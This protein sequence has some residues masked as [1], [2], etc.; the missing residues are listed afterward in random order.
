M[1]TA[2]RLTDLPRFEAEGLVEHRRELAARIGGE[3]PALL[4][5]GSRAEAADEV[6]KREPLLLEQGERLVRAA[7]ARG[8]QVANDDLLLGWMFR[9]P[10]G[11]RLL[12]DGLCVG[13]L[14]EQG[15][16][17]EPQHG[18]LLQVHRA[19]RQLIE[20]PAKTVP[21]VAP[22]QRS[23]GALDRAGRQFD[24]LP[25]ALLR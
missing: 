3:E 4:R 17:Q 1:F 6:G 24:V 19:Q 16:R 10:S 5:F 7:L 20:R 18:P 12:G 23:H 21:W 2:Q 9:N 11:D 14:F 22:L 13:G 8:E 15:L 25:S